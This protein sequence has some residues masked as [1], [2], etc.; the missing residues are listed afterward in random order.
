MVVLGYVAIVGIGIVLGSMGAGGSMLAIPVLVYIFMIDVDTASAYSLFLVGITSLAGAGLN[1]RK[2]LVS[3]RT[4]FGFGIPSVT[5]AF[6]CRKW[7]IVLIPDLIWECGGLQITKAH[8]LLVLF[9]VLMTVSSVAMLVKQEPRGPSLCRP[10]G[11][12]LMGLGFVV[13]CVASLAGAGGGFLILPALII[14]AR[15]PFATAA[16]TSLLIIACNCLVAF[17]GDVLN[18]AIDWHFLLA[19]T[20]LAILGLLS[21][22]WWH[23]KNQCRVSWKRGFAWFTMAVGVMILVKEMVL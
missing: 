11:P 18:R 23:R 13:G 7:I 6:I 17:C 15:L 5:G 1:R 8:T 19:L 3:M 2:Q 12:R 4:A 22:Y 20:A 21:G 10:D 14:L 9:S 16:G